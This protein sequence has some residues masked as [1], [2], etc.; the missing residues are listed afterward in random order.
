MSDAGIRATIEQ[1]AD[2]LARRLTMFVA[3]P[4]TQQN[5]G[6][7][8]AAFPLANA[9]ATP[10]TGNAIVRMDSNTYG[11]TDVQPDL[12]QCP[13]AV[14]VMKRLSRGVLLGR[15]GNA[16][17]PHL[18]A[19]DVLICING[20]RGRKR[21]FCKWLNNAVGGNDRD[22]T[23][24]HSLIMHAN[25]QSWWK[26]RLHAHGRARLTQHMHVVASAK[27]HRAIK[28]TTFNHHPGSTRGD[29]LG[30]VELDPL[31]QLPKLPPAE[32]TLYLGKS[33]KVLASGK[34]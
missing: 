4:P 23:I 26:R 20:G 13:I 34:G 8:I 25:E 9:K 30:P 10:E 28:H 19:G 3:E 33:R 16:E 7:L 11:E 15:F 18:R 1:T 5:L 12:R 6:E 24:T 22:R 2:R 29:I 32:K 21:N 27:T 14:K 17:P 31:E